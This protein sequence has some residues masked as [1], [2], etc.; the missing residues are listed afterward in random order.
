[1]KQLILCAPCVYSMLYCGVKAYTDH[2]CM[3]Q[4]QLP[5]TFGKVKGLHLVSLVGLLCKVQ[6]AEEY[7]FCCELEMK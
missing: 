1:M 5:F 4:V 7:L 2:T 3:F 6:C